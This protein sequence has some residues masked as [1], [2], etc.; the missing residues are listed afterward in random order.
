M[1]LTL[2]LLKSILAMSILL[3]LYRLFLE[4]EKMHHFNRF[5]LLGAI[6]FSII[7]PFLPTG[8]AFMG[9]VETPSVGQILLPNVEIGQKI[10]ES[11]EVLLLSPTIVTIILYLMVFSYL[12]VKFGK[13]LLSLIKKAKI[14][15]TLIYKG[16]KIV[17]LEKCDSPFTFWNYIYLTRAEYESN[18]VDRQLLDHELTHARQKH[19]WDVIFVEILMVIFW[20]NPILRWYKTAIQLNHEFLADDAVIEKYKEVKSY[21]YLLLDTIQN[22]NKIYL[23]SNINFHLTQKRLKMMT[24]KSSSKRKKVLIFSMLPIVLIL[25]FSLGSPAISQNQNTQIK[26][27]IQVD[28]SK[29]K[30]R[31]FGQAIVHYKTEDGKTKVISYKSLNKAIKSK[32]P[33]PP[34]MPPS[35]SGRKQHNK[36]IEPL[37][38]GTVVFL[39]ENG[40]I[41]ID[42][43]DNTMAPPPPPSVN[44]NVQKAPKAPKMAKAPKAVKPTKEIKSPKAPK[45]PKAVKAPKPPKAHR[46][47]SID[48]S[49]PPPPPPP[50]PPTSIKDLAR[51]GAIFYIDDKK[52]SSEIAIKLWGQDG[53]KVGSIDVKSGHD[54]KTSVY[55]IKK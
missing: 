10:S 7:I 6:V 38:K 41:R 43:N 4:K 50:P 42:N 17:L 54:G 55:L 45:A 32:I 3:V 47:I 28:P 18:R 53:N 24:K 11:H 5:Y 36:E 44:P 8:L 37:P 30:D 12:C 20:F 34:P 27:E 21:Q 1:I 33:P 23:A 46:G 51:D 26:N 52:V 15:Q 19:S 39:S 9:T 49:I 25:L 22:N 14:N 29:A 13:N 35:P 48:G 16:A 2:Y 31:Y 40:S